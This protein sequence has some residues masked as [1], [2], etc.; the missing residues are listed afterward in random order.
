MIDNNPLHRN[1]KN[2]NYFTV[3]I[4]LKYPFYMVNNS[5]HKGHNCIAFNSGYTKDKWDDHNTFLCFSAHTERKLVSG[6]LY[7]LL[8]WHP[9]PF[10][11]HID[12]K[13][14]VPILPKMSYPAS[15]LRTISS[16]AKYKL[17]NFLHTTTNQGKDYCLRSMVTT[18][19]L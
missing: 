11:L 14:G 18:K 16:Q 15:F 19:T 9:T 8:Q 3:L 7:L 17:S 1:M 10:C 4:G 13:N 2:W 12:C 6:Y 5:V